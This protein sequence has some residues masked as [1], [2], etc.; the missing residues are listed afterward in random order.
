MKYRKMTVRWLAVLLAVMLLLSACHNAPTAPATEQTS[1]NQLANPTQGG[2][3]SP[4]LPNSTQPKPTDV[5]AHKDGNSDETCDSCGIDVTVELDFYGIND[6]HGVFCDSITSPGVD[7]LTTYLKNAIADE[8]AHEI[9]ISSGDMWQGSIESNSNRGALMTEWMNDIGFVSMTLGNHE[10]DWGSE[11][12]SANAEIAEFPFLGINIKDSNAKSN[13][14]KPSVV[15]DR[16]GVRIGIIG[17]IGNC[18]SSISGEFQ[19]GLSFAVYDELTALVKAEATRL[20]QQEYCDL[21]IYSI[22]DGSTNRSAGVTNKLGDL[23]DSDGQTYYDVD[24]SNGYVD[25]V[26]EGHSHSSYIIKDQHGVYHLQTGGNNSTLGFANICYN[27]VTD[28]YEVETVKH[29]PQNEYTNENI[30]DDPIVEE[31]VS[32]YFPDGDPYSHVVGENSKFRGTDE[33]CSVLA[34]LYWKAGKEKWGNQFDVV[35]GGGF[36]SCRGSGL[37]SGTVTFDQ[38]YRLFPFD[39]DIVLGKISGAKL[40]SQFISPT[41]SAAGRYFVAYDVLPSGIQN[42]KMYYIVTD[43]YTSTYAYNQITEVE[44][45]KGTYARDLL[46]QYIAEG[47]FAGINTVTIQKALEIGN[48]LAANETSAEVYKLTGT[49]QSLE[50]TVWGNLYIADNAGNRIYLYGLYDS[51]GQNRYDAL[52]RKPIEGDV[53]TVTGPITKYYN[54]SSGELKIEI[55]SA[56]LQSFAAN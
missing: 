41:G 18:K 13:Y 16:G 21:V 47:N 25:L 39:N 23:K 22:H 32:K 45:I 56:A 35:L 30:A 50:N 54:Q 43:T 11:Y 26:V 9:I 49:V 8:T 38:L 2:S 29:I 31:L 20:R 42:D 36:L 5:C 14:C 4:T 12:I 1:G 52:P 7:E 15:I 46:R 37:N 24:L 51:A 55:K 33:L 10:F 44:R 40:K 28:T 53:I 19:G 3:V 34:Q 17:A 6:L 48:A 27:L